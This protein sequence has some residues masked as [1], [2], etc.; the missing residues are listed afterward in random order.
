[1][2][3]DSQICIREDGMGFFCRS[4]RGDIISKW[5]YKGKGWTKERNIESLSDMYA[6]SGEPPQYGASERIGVRCTSGML[7]I[8]VLF[9][10]PVNILLK[11]KRN[12]E[13]VDY[14]NFKVDSLSD[15]ITLLSM[16]LEVTQ[17]LA[18][19]LVQAS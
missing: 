10:D 15:I 7:I 1:M 2:N 4:L 11:N 12:N 8:M 3:T 6:K 19:E 17:K 16:P 5:T 18:E 14:S 13:Q 9:H